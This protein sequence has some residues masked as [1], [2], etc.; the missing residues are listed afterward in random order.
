[1][2]ILPINLTSA[3]FSRG[4]KSGKKAPKPPV[5]KEKTKS[6]DQ[7]Q[8]SEDGR[9]KVYPRRY[10]EHDAIVRKINKDTTER[11]KAALKSTDDTESV[12]DILSERDAAL[13][14]AELRSFNVKTKDGKFTKLF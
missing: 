9:L 3:S 6:V 14:L 13:V 10:A 8:R 4:K 11:L 2:N 1:M 5:E 12:A 7:F